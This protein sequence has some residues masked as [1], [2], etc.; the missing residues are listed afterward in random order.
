MHIR[1]GSFIRSE[2]AG[3][4]GPDQR[5]IVVRRLKWHRGTE[6]GPDRLERV[7]IAAA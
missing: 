3:T 1:N 4:H 2:T 7:E 6:H 5:W